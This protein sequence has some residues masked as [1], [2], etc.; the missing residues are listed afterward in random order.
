MALKRTEDERGVP[1]E[2]LMTVSELGEFL[3]VPEATL[4]QW[5]YRREGPPALKVGRHLRW[6]PR[7][8]EA[9]LNSLGGAGPRQG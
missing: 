3:G 4:Y 7:D 6:R 8:V 1:S 9:W 2:K 5:R